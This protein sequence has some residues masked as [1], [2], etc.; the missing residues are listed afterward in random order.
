MMSQQKFDSLYW[1][2]NFA[3]KY[4]KSIICVSL[5]VFPA[6]DDKQ[7]DVVSPEIPAPRSFSFIDYITARIRIKEDTRNNIIQS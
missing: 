2:Q 7:W 1:C 6:Y 3:S 5:F 4:K